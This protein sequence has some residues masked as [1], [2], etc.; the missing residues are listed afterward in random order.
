MTTLQERLKALRKSLNLTQ[1]A[2]GETLGLKDSVIS[3]IESAQIPL[4]DKNIE[5]I[6][7][8]HNVNKTWLLTGK[9]DMFKERMPDVQN[10]LDTYRKL[11]PSMQKCI[12]KIASTLLETQ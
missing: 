2:F 4:T 10:L 8:K 5:L 7:L 11:S 3:R 1:G 6:C 9:G 12:Q